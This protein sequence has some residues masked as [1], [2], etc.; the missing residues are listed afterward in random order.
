M[1]LDQL[2][3]IL[4]AIRVTGAETVQIRTPNLDGTGS[5]RLIGVR[6]EGETVVLIASL[7]DERYDALEKAEKE[8]LARAAY[9]TSVGYP[10]QPSQA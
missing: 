7:G 9:M 10:P 1:T 2:K 5:M 8:R 6:R 4:M 3:E